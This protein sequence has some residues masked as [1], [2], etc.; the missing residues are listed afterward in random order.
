MPSSKNEIEEAKR[1]IM[2]RKAL[3]KFNYS[4]NQH[5]FI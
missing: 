3:P 1:V 4:L 2:S 5:E